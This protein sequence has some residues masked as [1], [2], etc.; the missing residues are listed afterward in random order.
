MPEEETVRTM[1]SRVVIADRV[2]RGTKF[3]QTLIFG[4]R[5]RPDAYVQP[6]YTF[7]SS[8]FLRDMAKRKWYVVVR[9]R[10]VG[11]FDTW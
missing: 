2:W 3:D 7:S 6:G 4:T 11:V 9:G 8:Y 1:P 5:L 10:G